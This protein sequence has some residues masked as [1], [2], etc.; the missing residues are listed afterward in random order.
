MIDRN[1]GQVQLINSADYETQTTYNFVV[2]ATLN[3]NDST[4]TAEEPVTLTINDVNDCLALAWDNHT[5]VRI[6]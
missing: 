6:I 5:H 2:I 1:T 4:S 3:L